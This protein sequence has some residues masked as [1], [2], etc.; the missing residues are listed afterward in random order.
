MQ[1]KLPEMTTYFNQAV[2]ITLAV[3][4]GWSGKGLSP[5]SFRIFG[6]AEPKHEN[7]RATFSVEK[8]D[9]TQDVPAGAPAQYGEAAMLE[10]IAQARADLK[11][12]MPNLRTLREERLVR[13][14]GLPAYAHW[15]NWL[16][17][18]AGHAYSQIQAL[19]LSADGSLYVFNAATL[20][21]LERAYLPVFEHMLNS[22]KIA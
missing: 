13:A 19:V 17:A 15:F 7:D 8:V 21:S 20:K 12:E 18:Q 11:D 9:L 1:E 6:P 22:A 4:V 2:G 5:L 10:L 16:D 3:P 14:D